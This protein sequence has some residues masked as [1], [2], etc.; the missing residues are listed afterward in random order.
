[1][2]TKESTILKKNENTFPQTPYYLID[3]SKILNI[4]KRIQYLREKSGVRAV[5]ALKC[6]STWP[7]FSLM[8]QYM[9]GTTS[10]SVYEAR[11]GFEE[12]GKEVHAYAAAFS[13]NDIADVK[14]ISDKIIF[15]SISQL[16]TFH[17]EVKGLEI[18][19]RVNPQVSFSHYDIADPAKRYSRLGEKDYESILAV[20]DLI[21]G[22]M[23]HYNCE[24]DDIENFT[25]TLDKISEKFS[26]LLYKLNWVSLGGGIS[27]TSD[28]YPVDVFAAKLSEFS[29]K[30][31]VQ[32][33]LEPG[34]ASVLECAQLVTQVLDIVHNEKDIAIV[35]ASIGAHKVDDLVYRSEAF[36]EAHAENGDYEY[37]IAGNSCLAGDIFGHYKFKTPLKVGDVVNIENAASYTMVSKNWFNGLRMPAIAIKRIDGAIDVVQRSG[38]QDFK[39]SLG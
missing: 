11:L 7:V 22:V 8:N 29:K 12:F 20:Q 5:L 35:N 18:G 2:E 26:D 31:D 32:V 19:L 23:F 17:D 38:Y 33:Y 6:F 3:E 27:F 21:N 34:E 24:N 37:I 15:N 25:A 36:I 16:K 28:D 9:D 13:E 1:M 4:M 14:K 39:K 10:S 30:F